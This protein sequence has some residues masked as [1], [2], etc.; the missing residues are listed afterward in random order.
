MKGHVV[1]PTPVVFLC[2]SPRITLTL[3]T[4][5]LENVGGRGS[6]YNKDATLYHKELATVP[7]NCDWHVHNL[8]R[9]GFE[10]YA[11]SMSLLFMV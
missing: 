9:N 6:L 8:R 2:K 11:V 10:R 5:F 1:V 7:A 4:A 3:Y